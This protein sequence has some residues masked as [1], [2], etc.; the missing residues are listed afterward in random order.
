[1]TFLECT[2]KHLSA[3]LAVSS[4]RLVE[5]AL[6]TQTTHLPS[7]LTST[8]EIS[9]NIPAKRMMLRLVTQV[10]DLHHPVLTMFHRTAEGL[11]QYVRGG[12]G[13]SVT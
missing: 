1:M 9:L 2:H 12:C 10:A 3:G 8:G 13:S 5:T 11:R 7:P 4:A 6:F